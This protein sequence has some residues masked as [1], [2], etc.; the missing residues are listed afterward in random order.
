MKLVYRGNFQPDLPE[1]VIPWSTE[2]HIALSWEALGHEVVR[3]QEN[4]DDWST[5]YE[6]SQGCDLFLWTS[7]FGYAESWPRDEAVTTLLKLGAEMPT[8][9]VHLDLWHGLERAAHHGLVGDLPLT[10]FFRC[11]HVFTADG[12]HDAEWIAAGVNHHYLPPGV[13]HGE[14]Y[15]ALPNPRR[16]PGKIAFVGSQ[17]YGHLEHAPVRT[18]ML[19]ALRRKYRGQFVCHPRRQAVRGADLNE[20]FA[21][22]PVIVGDSCLA[23]QIPNYISDRVPETIGRGGFLIHPH[24]TGI[25]NLFPSLVVFEPGNWGQLIEKVDYY[26]EHEA[27]R[28]SLRRDNAVWARTHHAYRNRAKTILDTIGLT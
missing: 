7:T 22:I 14:A 15:D 2:H 28:E 18:A 26:L 4:T 17:N 24:V 20:L 6:K 16:W 19:D 13:F 12:G 11:Q 21:T 23:G 9:G 25:L 5:T 3:S 10:P 1:G 8:C 27:A